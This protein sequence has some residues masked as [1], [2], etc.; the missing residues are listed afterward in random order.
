LQAGTI[1]VLN[2]FRARFAA[3]VL[4]V[5]TALA[6]P[7]AAAGETPTDFLKSYV[8]EWTGTGNVVG[9]DMPETFTCRLTIAPGTASKVNYVGRC[10]LVNL[11][12]SVRGTIAYVESTQR[13]EAAM[14]SNTQFSGVAGG[15]RRGDSI[16]FD[17]KERASDARGNAIQIASQIVLQGGNIQIDFDIEF[18]NSGQ[19]LHAAVPFRR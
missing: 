5:L 16:V 6:G 17:L 7:V 11:N 18:N 3:M 13:Y 4:L 2:A 19:K 15:V 9:G 14:S 12:L 10:S 8:G 1:S